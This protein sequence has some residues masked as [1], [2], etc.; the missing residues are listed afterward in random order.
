MIA[1]LPKALLISVLMGVVVLACGVVTLGQ[2][3]QTD[4]HTLPGAASI[5]EGCAALTEQAQLLELLETA[6]TGGYLTDEQA[7]SILA[8]AGVEALDAGD[9]E[10]AAEVQAALIMIL[11]AIN[12]EM[13]DPEGAVTALTVAMG[14]EALLEALA[15]LLDDQASP[16][17]VL[18]AI[19]NAALKTGYV[20]SDSGTLFAQIEIAIQGGVPPGIVVRVAKHAL[21]SGLDPEEQ[22]SLLEEQISLLA[23][24][25]ADGETPPGHAAN[26]VTGKGQQKDQTGASNKPDKPKKDNKGQ[27]K[28]D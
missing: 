10:G 24:L 26:E 23:E 4:S 18:N 28:K 19:W 8:A 12:A 27:S 14:E 7:M 16:P 15:A 13:I 17:G 6:G 25:L 3:V 22:I 11:N 2:E 9:P 21:R 5:V 20:Q 1:R